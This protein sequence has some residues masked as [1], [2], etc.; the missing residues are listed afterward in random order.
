MVNRRCRESEG[1]AKIEGYMSVSDEEAHHQSWWRAGGTLESGFSNMS[2]CLDHQ[3]KANSI[4]NKSSA[5]FHQQTLLVLASAVSLSS[6]FLFNMPEQPCENVIWDE[7]ETDCM[8]EY[9]CD[10]TSEAGDGGNFKETAYW[11]AAPYCKSSP[12]KVSKHVKNK[13][14]TISFININCS[15]LIQIQHR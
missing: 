1:K 10:H 2:P 3:F 6:F 5:R 8:M 4:D 9:L 14:K 7:K 13:Y 11:G 15:I 12:I